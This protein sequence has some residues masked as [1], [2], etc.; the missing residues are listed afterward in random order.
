MLLKFK[1]NVNNTGILSLCF[2]FFICLKANAQTGILTGKAIDQTTG[3]D[4]VGAV[5]GV[6]GTS[7][8]SAVDLDGKYA[9]KI[10]PGTYNIFCSL[11]SYSK[12]TITGVVIKAGEVT[13][14]DF[15]L[16]QSNTDLREVVIEA[17]Q[18]KNTDASL[19][20]IQRKAYAVQ[21]GVSSQQISRTGSSN[22]AE[23]MKQMAG[24]NV[25]D[26]KFMVMRGL[27]DRYSIAQING[28]PM[29]SSDPYRNASSLDLIPSNFID[30]IITIKTF[31]PD[32][33]GNFA[34]GNVN[35]TT[36]SIPEKFFLNFST[37]QA[38]NT[39]ASLN[40]QFQT[41]QGGNT[42]WI[43]MDDGTRAM[44]EYLRDDS[45]RNLLTSALYV[46][47]R[48]PSLQNE[49]HRL[50]FDKSSRSFSSNF[51]PV[52]AGSN[53]ERGFGYALRQALGVSNMFNRT[54]LNSSY[55][56]SIGNK[57]TVLG[58]DI[59]FTA[60]ANYSR[61]FTYYADGD[62][63]TLI[64]AGSDSLFSYQSLK[65][66]KSVDN[67]QLGGLA[68][69]SIKLNTNNRIG[70]TGFYS[71][72]AEKVSREQTGSFLG[73]VSE[74]RAVFNTRV[75]EF[76]QRELNSIV[77]NGNHVL[78]VWHGM[79]IDWSGSHTKSLQA[80]PDLRYFAFTTLIDS[81]DSLDQDGNL[82]FRYQ[83][84]IYSMNNAEFAFPYHFYRELRDEQVQGKA[85]I[86]INLD[87]TQ[88]NKLKA[89]VFYSETSRNFEEFRY[90][91][92]NSGAPGTLNLNRFNGDINALMNPANFGI[93]DTTVNAEG[94]VTRYPTGWHYINQVNLR[95][96]Y[97]GKQRVS[98][99][100]LMG[101]V[102]PLDMLRVVGGIRIESTQMNVQSKDTTKTIFVELNGDTVVDPGVITLTDLLPSL[103]LIFASGENSNIRVAYSRTLARPN[104]RELAP[105][106]QFDTKNGFF[107]VGN[108]GLTRTLIDNYDIR[109]EWFPAIGEI[110]ALSGFYK[111]FKDPIIK[112]F[113]PK[114]TIPELTFINVPRAT[115]YGLELEFRK[116]LV[117][118]HESL[119]QFYFNTNI[120]LMQSRVDIPKT[121]IE[122]HKQIDSTYTQSSRPFQGQSPYI[123][124]AILSYLNP[125]IGNE[126]A[127]SFNVSG[128][129]LY[130][131]SLFATPDI[132]EEAV[133]TLNLRSVQNI[134]KH[135]QVSFTARNLLNPEIRKTQNFRGNVFIA[136][137]FAI[138]RTFALG[139]SYRIR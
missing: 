98:A 77:L 28:L 52:D 90:Q 36:K 30:N 82:L 16:S 38:F 32:Q 80:E 103:N 62:V 88:E 91:M 116:S 11:I 25:E 12:K 58:K 15:V 96:F 20:S 74:S 60:G 83:D 75:Q 107:S 14:L 132:Y 94:K 22:A 5:V 106:S 111:E 79:E 127:L 45:V 125:E 95:N 8:A 120:T 26:G 137:S 55:N 81:L 66:R 118:I 89:G 61:N 114:A 43:G 13:T 92:N 97:S 71:N 51:A 2:V 121:E 49:E 68:N 59:G 63:R 133:P 10:A 139:I 56:F 39:Q 102:K 67:P 138:G 86:T 18:V 112:A 65:E 40:S 17:A 48:N 119:K 84:T 115:L 24:A 35:I 130:N 46:K 72:D 34:G 29:P 87:K 78:P 47:A 100:Y 31:T 37:S 104:M 136:E 1:L 9:L 128:R 64:N 131:I 113:N 123:I 41:Y 93:I 19:I 27:G 117:M 50:L 122:N 33:P 108:P 54:P 6:E 57:W 129:R 85:D 53:Q 23:G 69:L 42:D 101:I 7:Q 135:W 105:F 76:T 126:T 73:Q 44:P 70:I 21:D 124:N 99:A 4:L 109:Y 134:G 3:E 110:I